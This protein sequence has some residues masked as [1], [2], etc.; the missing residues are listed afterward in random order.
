MLLPSSSQTQGAETQML[1][2]VL[3]ELFPNWVKRHA[4]RSTSSGKI[5]ALASL[6][7]KIKMA[8]K[9]NPA[10]KNPEVPGQRS[11]KTDPASVRS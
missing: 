2:S 6:Q 7:T 11:A 3:A 5:S 10:V 4:I 8:D 1:R 9:Q